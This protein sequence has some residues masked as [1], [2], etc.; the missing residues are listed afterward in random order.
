VAGDCAATAGRPAST[1]YRPSEE[2]RGEDRCVEA[3]GCEVD[4]WAVLAWRCDVG[5]SGEGTVTVAANGEAV[6]GVA[7]DCSASPSGV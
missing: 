7:S 1:S 6:A 4:A 3:G 2:P 5:A